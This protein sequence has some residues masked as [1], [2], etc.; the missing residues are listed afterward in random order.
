M[1]FLYFR[2]DSNVLYKSYAQNLTIPADQEEG[3][4]AGNKGPP[5]MAPPPPGSNLE[6]FRPPDKAV[7]TPT[8]AEVAIQVCAKVSESHQGMKSCWIYAQSE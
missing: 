2:W 1:I 5:G 8:D 7:T 3:I 6:Q 4:P